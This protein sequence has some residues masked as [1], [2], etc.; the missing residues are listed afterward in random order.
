MHAGAP[1]IMQQTIRTCGNFVLPL[2]LLLLPQLEHESFKASVV[3][4]VATAL[5]MHKASFCA[6]RK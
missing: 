6:G 5:S 2:L 1:V 3:A 4:V